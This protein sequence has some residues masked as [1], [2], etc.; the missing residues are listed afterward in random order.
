MGP[1][2]FSVCR[3]YDLEPS[4]ERP[5]QTQ[6][7]SKRQKERLQNIKNQG[8]TSPLLNNP[9]PQSVT[10]NNKVNKQSPHFPGSLLQM[11][12]DTAQSNGVKINLESVMGSL[13]SRPPYR[14]EKRRGSSISKSSASIPSLSAPCQALLL[15]GVQPTKPL[16]TA[17]NTKK[18]NRNS[19][20]F[21][22]S[23]PSSQYAKY[24]QDEPNLVELP[25][26]MVNGAGDLVIKKKQIM[27]T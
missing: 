18:S 19:G 1:Q 24:V 23:M 6:L 13:Y 15:V 9:Q 25:A 20:A 11:T 27:P 2:M 10:V 22:P 26:L 12:S 8:A 7:W 16:G 3:A 17:K 14:N 5:S 4:S 21:K